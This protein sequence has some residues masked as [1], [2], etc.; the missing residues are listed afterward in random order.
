[1][2]A[3]VTKPVR[4]ERPTACAPSAAAAEAGSGQHPVSR[5][6]RFFATFADQWSWVPNPAAGQ[7][8]VSSEAQCADR[9]YGVG[10]PWL[11]TLQRLQRA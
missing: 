9:C 11:R 8:A 5:T 7:P 4:H 10:A 3:I 2:F 1:M 6:R